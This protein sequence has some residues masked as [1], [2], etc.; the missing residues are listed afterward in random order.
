MLL[1]LDPRRKNIIEADIRNISK[2]ISDRIR[3]HEDIYWAAF[4]ANIKMDGKTYRK[5]KGLCGLQNK[6]E[7]PDLVIDPTDHTDYDGGVIQSDSSIIMKTNIDKV[8]ALA[9]NFENIH[10]QNRN[11]GSV[12]HTQFVDSS[13]SDISN[14]RNPIITFN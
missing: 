14:N 3:L 9:K 8:N 11:I 2:I 1:C 6:I 7:L 12:A 10:K 5:I 4:F 13:I